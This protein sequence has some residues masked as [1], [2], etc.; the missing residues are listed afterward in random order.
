MSRARSGLRHARS[1][2]TAISVATMVVLCALPRGVSA[3]A[4]PLVPPPASLDG[5]WLQTATALLA[6]GKIDEATALAYQRG[7]ADPDARVILARVAL[8][9]G[10]VDEAEGLLAPA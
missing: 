8:R 4:P 3:Q 7:Q 9:T 5:S 6:H 1:V 2:A 10:R